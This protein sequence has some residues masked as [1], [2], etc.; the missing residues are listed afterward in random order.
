MDSFVF[1]LAAKK[2]AVNL[3]KDMEDL[4]VYCPERKP[5]QNY[6]ITGPFNVMSEI[7]EATSAILDHKMSAVINKYPEYIDYIHISDQYSGAKQTEDSGAL[8]LPETEKVSYLLTLR[9]FIIINLD[10][11]PKNRRNRSVRL[12]SK[13]IGY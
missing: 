2:T 3:V 9:F 4:S 5:G 7:A 11:T 12:N 6:N 10:S 8:K 1:C 13:D